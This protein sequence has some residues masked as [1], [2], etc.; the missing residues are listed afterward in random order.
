MK[1]LAAISPFSLKNKMLRLNE[2]PPSYIDTL[3]FL[4]FNDQLTKYEFF[5]DYCAL[6]SRSESAAIPWSEEA[7]QT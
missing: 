6:C 7:I 1:K 3:F 2:T 4:I 5:A